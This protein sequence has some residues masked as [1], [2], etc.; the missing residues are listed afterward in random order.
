MII[1]LLDD[2]EG[3]VML[4]RTMIEQILG[5]QNC[6]IITGRN[7]QEGLQLLAGMDPLPDL[8]ISNFR[9]PAMDGLTFFAHIRNTPRWQH[10]RLV[11]MS[12]VT[13]AEVHHAAASYEVET[14]LDK[15]FRLE[16]L[17]RVIS[18]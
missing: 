2:N 14:F 1:L 7:G 6:T 11:M 3:I 16:D 17:R 12:A 9:M 4:T 13:S 8:I 5:R 10:I 15:P 18:A